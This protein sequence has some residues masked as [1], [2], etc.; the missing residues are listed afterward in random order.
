MIL[1][2]VLDEVMKKRSQYIETFKD[3]TAQE[4]KLTELFDEQGRLEAQRTVVSDF[5]VYPSQV[6]D[7]VV[8]E[9]RVVRDVDGKP[10]SNSSEQA[11]RLIEQLAKTKTL[12]AEH[13]RLVEQ[14]MKYNLHYY[15]WDVTLNPARQFAEAAKSNY[16]YEILGNEKLGS[17]EVVVLGYRKKSFD[18]VNARGIFS[19][20]S[21]PEVSD[22]GR[23]WVDANT[24]KICQWENELVVR[25]LETGNTLVVMRDQVEYVDSSFGILVPK[26]ITI[27]FFDRLS[28]KRGNAAPPRTLLSGR[29]TYRYDS[30]K[31][32]NV[33]GDYE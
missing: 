15:R 2:K 32:F 10:V 29:I 27:T 33:T 9:Y 23:L 8:S 30:F 16:T 19:D 26:T 14:N 7:G 11:Q 22:R 21:N 5:L 1:Q 31:R 6:N 24:F 17:R 12:T 18:P 25:H 4:T 20:F 3:L 13:K 28:Y